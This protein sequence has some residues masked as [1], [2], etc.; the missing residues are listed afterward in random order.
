[1]NHTNGRKLAVLDCDLNIG[2]HVY[3]DTKNMPV[4]TINPTGNNPFGNKRFIGPFKVLA[5]IGAFGFQLDVP[6][7]MR[8]HPVFHRSRLIETADECLYQIDTVHV[9]NN[10]QK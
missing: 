8:I 9:D 5:K 4:E 2:T 3:L 1:M 7:S 6:E 10:S